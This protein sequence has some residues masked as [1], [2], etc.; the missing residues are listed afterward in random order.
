MKLIPLNK[1]SIALIF[2]AIIAIGFFAAGLFEVLDYVI[3]KALLFTGFG[4]LFVIAIVFT[5]KNENKKNRPK[6]T[7]QDDSH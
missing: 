6:E 3:I 4:F 7:L 1:N 2:V 5:I